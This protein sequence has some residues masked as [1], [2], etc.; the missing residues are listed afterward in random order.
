MKF[1]AW[2]TII[3]LSFA[4]S[5]TALAAPQL[6]VEQ[7]HYNFGTVL[8]GKAVDHVFILK[9][10][11]DSPLQIKQVKPA[12][13]CT[14]ATISSATILPGKKGE[15]KTTFNSTN[16]YGQVKKEVAVET[17]DPKT[18]TYNLT[19]SGTI[20]EEIEVNPKQLNFGK[21]TAG[22]PKTLT[23]TIDNKSGKPLKLSSPKASSPQTTVKP[24][25][26]VI[27]TGGSEI[28]TVTVT[29]RETDRVISGY[30]SITSDNP[31]KPTISVPYYGSPSK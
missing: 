27:S 28:V 5:A 11:G 8:Q 23:F 21:M 15:I 24:A 2:A 17:N 14:A 16:F 13:G 10:G 30:V 6:V 31:S 3:L 25:H 1:Y 9:N 18:P 7:P 20:V 19:L 4:M 26:N 29:S 22:T 12:C